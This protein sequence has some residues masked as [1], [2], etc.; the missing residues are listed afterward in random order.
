MAPGNGSF[1]WL[2]GSVDG[3]ETCSNQRAD[4]SS[5]FRQ[6]AFLSAVFGNAADQKLD[7]CFPEK[8]ACFVCFKFT[9]ES[10]I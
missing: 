3:E 1:S 6:F 9:T 5:N 8:L 10:D 7:S 2:P 4:K